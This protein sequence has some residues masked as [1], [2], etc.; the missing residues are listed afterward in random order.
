[1]KFTKTEIGLCRQI[2]EKHKKEIQYGDWFIDPEGH[3]VVNINWRPEGDV[4]LWTI[5]DC[6]EF[7]REKSCSI[8]LTLYPGEEQWNSGVEMWDEDG[9]KVVFGHDWIGETPL[10]ALLKAVLAV[11]EEK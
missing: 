8:I 6:L 9:D 3:E 5:E 10:E 7:L 1:M 4:P 11:L 2:A